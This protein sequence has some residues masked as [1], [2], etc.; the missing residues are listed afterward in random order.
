MEGAINVG[1]Q[2]LGDG[3]FTSLIV[4]HTSR[5]RV[6]SQPHYLSLKTLL[7]ASVFNWIKLSGC[8]S[9]EP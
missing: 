6:D 7:P 1:L 5:N 2:P 8:T 9:D 4:C 3:A